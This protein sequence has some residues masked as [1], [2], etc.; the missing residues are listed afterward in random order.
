MSTWTTSTWAWVV[1]TAGAPVCM[2]ST[3]YSLADSASTSTCFLSMRA[4]RLSAMRVKHG[5]RGALLDDSKIKHNNSPS[6]QLF[7]GLVLS[8]VPLPY[9]VRKSLAATTAGDGKITHFH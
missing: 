1:M 6:H 4:T 9:C 2:K 5:S 8:A 3:L 7:P